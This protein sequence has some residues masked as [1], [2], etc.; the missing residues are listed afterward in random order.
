MNVNNKH[1]DGICLLAVLLLIRQSIRI[2]SIGASTFHFPQLCVIMVGLLYVI[3]RKCRFRRKRGVGNRGNL[4]LAFS[5]MCEVSE[6]DSEETA[7]YHIPY[8]TVQKAIRYKTDLNFQLGI[9]IP[10]YPKFKNY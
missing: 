10:H 1:K 9:L 4:E 8:V 2:A 6:G 3:G 5:V 7:S